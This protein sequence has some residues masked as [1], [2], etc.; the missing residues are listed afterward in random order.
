VISLKEMIRG[1]FAQ[2]SFAAAFQ[3]PCWPFS[4][5]EAA[6]MLASPRPPPLPIF[7]FSSVSVFF[8]YIF[9]SASILILALLLFFTLHF[10]FAEYAAAIFSADVSSAVSP[11]R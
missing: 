1:V 9:S 5:S 8:D 6:S 7:A 2:P 10:D 11:L 3:I 4:S